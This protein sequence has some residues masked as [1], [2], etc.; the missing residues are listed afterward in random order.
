MHSDFEMSPVFLCEVLV[1]ITA[2]HNLY[3]KQTLVWI[4]EQLYFRVGM[5]GSLVYYRL[6]S[7]NIYKLF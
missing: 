5:R 4:Q 2:Q 7:V 3:R 1:L 6:K